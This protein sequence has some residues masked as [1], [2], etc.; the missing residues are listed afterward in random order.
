M[1]EGQFSKLQPLQSRES[2]SESDVSTDTERSSSSDGDGERL[3]QSGS[4]KAPMVPALDSSSTE[5]SESAP[6][7]PVPGFSTAN[8]E[9]NTATGPAAVPETTATSSTST[10][11]IPVVQFV[12]TPALESQE[13]PMLTDETNSSGVSGLGEGQV[14]KKVRRGT[15]SGKSRGYSSPATKKTSGEKAS[16]KE[17]SGEKATSSIP[18]TVTVPWEAAPLMVLGKTCPLKCVSDRS[19]KGRSLGHFRMN[20][21]AFKVKFSCPGK[22]LQCL[23]PFPADMRDHERKHL[24]VC[25]PATGHPALEFWQLPGKVFEGVPAYHGEGMF[26]DPYLYMMMLMDPITRPSHWILRMSV[27]AHLYEQ[28]R[29]LEL[30]GGCTTNVQELYVP[31]VVYHGLNQ[32]IAVR[33]EKEEV[34]TPAENEPPTGY[35]RKT[36]ELPETDRTVKEAKRLQLAAG[37]GD[38]KPMCLAHLA[39]RMNRRFEDRTGVPRV[40]RSAVTARKLSSA[41]KESSRKKRKIDLGSDAVQFLKP[42]VK[43]GKKPAATVTSETVSQKSVRFD[44]QT[45]ESISH[46]PR[47]EEYMDSADEITQ[48]LTDAT[49]RSAS[50]SSDSGPESATGLAPPVVAGGIF[51]EVPLGNEVT[52]ISEVRTVSIAPARTQMSSDMIT[53][54]E[55]ALR[56]ARQMVQADVRDAERV[57]HLQERVKEAEADRDRALQETRRVELER[58]QAL[59]EAQ[60]ERREKEEALAELVELRKAHQHPPVDSSAVDQGKRAMVAL[61][62]SSMIGRAAEALRRRETGKLLIGVAASEQVFRSITLQHQGSCRCYA[63]AQNALAAGTPLPDTASNPALKTYVEKV[64]RSLSVRQAV[65]LDAY[66]LGSYEI[67]EASDREMVMQAIQ[68]GLRN[69]ATYRVLDDS[70]CLDPWQTAETRVQTS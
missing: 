50:V 53:G 12:R 36:V 52:L 13:T 42:G 60:R 38:D 39:R 1:A 55:E 47:A 32:L 26:V 3:L 2:G 22:N 49:L 16:G 54:L 6:N 27:C 35:I 65:N 68:T 63:A 64:L 41:L 11:L 44:V 46:C 45:P 57:I 33:M 10:G 29:M 8:P 18:V 34:V 61:V 30:Y 4:G 66:Q 19:S 40:P 23:R 48:H 7:S 20:H 17:A 24:A 59:Q 43:P 31:A 5:V 9:V 37:K 28:L 56:R 21:Q 15:H 67:D 51:P 14:K 62:E 69:P 70:L 58:D 25:F